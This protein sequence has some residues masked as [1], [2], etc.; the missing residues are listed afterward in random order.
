[1]HAIAGFR[2]QPGRGVRLAITGL[3]ANTTYHFRIVATNAGGES[4]GSDQT[5][6]TLPNAPAVVTEAASSVT[7]TSATLNAT[8][9]PEGGNVTD[10]HFEYGTTNA[11]G[12]SAPCTPSPASET[13]PVAVSASLGILDL[14]AN[15]AYHFRIVATNAGGESKGSDQTFTTLPNA[16]AVVTEA[17]SSVTQTSATLNATVNPEGGNVTDCHFEYGTTNA[18][19][20]SAPCTPS[21]ASETSPVAVSASLRILGLTANTTYHFRIV[22]TNAGG[23]SKGSDQTFET[24]PNA[25]A[26]NSIEPAEGPTAGGTEVKI[27]GAGFEPGSTVTIGSPATD[28]KVESKTEIK[29]KTAAGSGSPE[30]VVSDVGG[31]SSGGPK[32][33]YVAPPAV[34]TKPASSVTQT[35]ATLNATVNPE[36]GATTDCH[37]EYGTSVIYDKSAPCTPSTVSGTSPVEVSASL[38]GLTANTEYHFRISAANA[39]GTSGGSDRDV[40]DAAQRPGGRD[41]TGLFGHPDHGDAERDGQPRRRGN[42]RLP[43]RIWD[44]GHL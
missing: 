34:V 31:S 6:T 37:F 33:T 9:N 36:G 26:V 22:A 16:P 7:Q 43:L 30:V 24:L 5:F 32:Y 13:S 40:H 8:V 25:P 18:Y 42:D 10:C 17:A 3:T 14:T 2:D 1:M 27:K 38:T 29:A 41:Q 21:P 44:L 28:V 11:Y 23:E 12:S 20:S 15:T 35:T 4:K 19:G 39:G